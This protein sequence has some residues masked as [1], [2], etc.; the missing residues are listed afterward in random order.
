M[1]CG[2][3]RFLQIIV[4]IIIILLMLI[5]GLLG[6]TYWKASFEVVSISS[7][8]KPWQNFSLTPLSYLSKPTA[9]VVNLGPLLIT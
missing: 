3:L 8:L 9:M 6:Y 2:E 4:F 5:L 1:I 7:N